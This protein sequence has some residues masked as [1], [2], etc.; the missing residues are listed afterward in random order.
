MFRVVFVPVHGQAFI[1][2]LDI[3]VLFIAHITTLLSPSNLQT[4]QFA[5]H[6]FDGNF[7]SALQ[8]GCLK[9][10]YHHEKICGEN[11]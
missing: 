6:T 1:Y 7:P 8:K 10:L 2:A 9:L 4:C 5:L 11:R 3:L